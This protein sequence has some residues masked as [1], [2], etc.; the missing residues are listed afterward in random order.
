MVVKIWSI[1]LQLNH[2]ISRKLIPYH[3]WYITELNTEHEQKVNHKSFCIHLKNSISM[4]RNFD[5]PYI[6]HPENVLEENRLGASCSDYSCLYAR[7]KNGYIYFDMICGS[8]FRFEV[9]LK[10]KYH[11]SCCKPDKLY[12]AIV[13]FYG[14]SGWCI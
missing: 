7:V 5:A 2:G 3:K 13:T 14:C 9:F 4:D 1:V 10:N 8:H 12:L 6:C 11:A